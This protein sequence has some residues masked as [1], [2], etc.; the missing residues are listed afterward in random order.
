MYLS[1]HRLLVLSLI[2]IFVSAAIAFPETNDSS[3][4]TEYNVK[5][6]NPAAVPIQSGINQ[7]PTTT[8]KS[9]SSSRS[10][11]ISSLMIICSEIGNCYL[12]RFKMKLPLATLV[13]A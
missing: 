9:D 2:C 5:P 3:T 4:N 1:N 8:S 10:L 7:P 6:N 13:L 11:F 12:F